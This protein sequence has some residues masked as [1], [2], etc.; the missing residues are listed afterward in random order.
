MERTKIIIIL[1]SLVA[2]GAEKVVLNFFNNIDI[3]YFEPILIIQNK[4]GP[5]NIQ[6]NKEKVIYLNSKKFRYAFLKLIFVL[7]QHKPKVI[8]STF[9]HITLS[10]LFFKKLLFRKTL[11]ISRV[12][13]M[14]KPSM[15]SS[16]FRIWIKLLHKLCMP[17]SSKIIVTSEAMRNDYVNS[18]IKNDKCLLLRNPI[19]SI[20]SR[21]INKL[22]RFPGEGLRLVFVGRLVHQKGLDRIMNLIKNIDGCH[23]TIIGD[24]PKRYSLENLVTDTKIVNKVK[25]IGYSDITNAY[26]A[27]ADYFLLPSRWEGLPNVALESLILGTPVIT[28]LEIKGLQDLLSLVP[29]NKL[30]FCK[31]V[32]EMEKLVSGLEVRADYLNPV[33]RDK[34][35]KEYNTPRTY[36]QKIEITIKELIIENR[37]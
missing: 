6:D 23:L 14:I 31:N 27:A 1:P 19:D 13:N 35:L 8:I 29:K 4:I 22:I 33:I 12:P 7:I 20:K 18:G 9:P 10:L 21:N 3:K 36:A 28:F 15:D 32:V 26:V 30:F 37:S 25:F 17:L 2:G 11:F 24:G 5:L 34:L 16:P